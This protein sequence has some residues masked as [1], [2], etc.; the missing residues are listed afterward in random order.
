MKFKKI[1]TVFAL[2]IIASLCLLFASCAKDEQD[3]KQNNLSPDIYPS[4][5]IE[6]EY[7]ADGL[8][9]V[10]TVYKGEKVYCKY[11]Y[12]YDDDGV[13]SKRIEKNKDGKT[14]CECEYKNGKTLLWENRYS[15][16]GTLETKLKYNKEG[17]V[18]RRVNCNGD[19]LANFII[20]YDE[21]GIV[22]KTT[23]NYYYHDNGSLSSTAITGEDGDC[24]ILYYT[25][26]G[27]LREAYI[28]N[29][30]DRELILERK[31]YSSDG[32]L[33]LDCFY[34][35]EGKEERAIEYDSDK[36]IK[37][38]KVF[39]EIGLVHYIEYENSM[40]VSWVEYKYDEN[41]KFTEKIEHSVWGKY[42]EPL[43]G[44]SDIVISNQTAQNPNYEYINDEEWQYPDNISAKKYFYSSDLI[45]E[46]GDTVPVDKLMT[47]FT[48]CEMRDNSNNSE[49]YE[50]LEQYRTDRDYFSIP[51]D[52]VN[53]EIEKHFAV[54]V[55][56]SDSQYTD[57]E[58][59]DHYLLTLCARGLM[60]VVMKDHAV[61]GN[62]S[63]A[64]Y[65][66]Y[67]SIDGRIFRKAE[68]CIENED[69]EEDFKIIYVREID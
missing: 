22:L 37:S 21:N 4:A 27:K 50:Y 32:K 47:Y 64:V 38:V 54:K 46:E 14:V 9:A 20:D 60:G 43:I 24:E 52:I 1:I 58:N 53:T 2:I 5:G 63:T 17:F 48:L 25:E 26:E 65:V 68:I 59:A 44:G 55:D 31:S 12:V 28:Y 39:S 15:D 8:P 18:T 66:L 69:S 56:G 33:T 62:R 45:F 3:I 67:D 29:N 49:L 51:K 13:L 7:N 35:S 61:D 30:A 6:Y 41:G 57:P 10:A 23:E 36:N 42:I 16:E 40:T 11:E 19:G 34:N